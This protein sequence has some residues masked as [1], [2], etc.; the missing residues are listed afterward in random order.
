MVYYVWLRF[1][2]VPTGQLCGRGAD[3]PPPPP[4]PTPPHQKK[5]REG[6]WIPNII[7]IGLQFDKKFDI[8]MRKTVVEIDRSLSQDIPHKLCY[9][10]DS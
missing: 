10:V 2:N 9:T 7:F 1:S 6:A 3:N 5:R 4:T 8:A